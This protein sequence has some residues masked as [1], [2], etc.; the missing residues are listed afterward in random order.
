MSP[1]ISPIAATPS[2]RT[3]LPD[4]TPNDDR[5]HVNVERLCEYLVNADTDEERH[6]WRR[7]I[8]V[9]CLPLA[10]RIAYRFVG[11]GEPSE[12]LLQVARIGLIKA[13]DRYDPA[14]GSF[15]S[16]AFAFIVGEVR[17]YFR[18]N[19]WGMHVPRGIK[20]IHRRVRA[21]TE[22]LS[23]R[24]GRA[25]TAAELAAELDLEPEAVSSAM[26]VEY[27]YHP[28]SLDAAGWASRSAEDGIGPGNGADDP[29]YSAVEDTMALA[30]LLA[31]L[32][33]R[34][35]LIVKMRFYQCLTQSE[36]SQH[37]GISQVHVSRILTAA[38][39][40]LRAQ[41]SDCPNESNR[42]DLQRPSHGSHR[43]F[44]AAG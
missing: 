11:R 23:Q 9:G 32:P 7:Q 26:E 19:A 27:A 33:E 34:Q 22:P 10:D 25:P 2:S 18:D 28:A 36:I 5:D 14:K 12:D 20:D 40:R 6:E 13:I 21:A 35:Q 39:E 30:R 17:R 41:L 1:K 24:L 42:H 4:T 31:Q 29:R 3:K 16:L 43:A 8:I 37:F 38:L 15:L 44:R